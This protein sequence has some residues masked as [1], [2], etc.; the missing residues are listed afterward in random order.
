MDFITAV[1]G[2]LAIVLAAYLAVAIAKPEIF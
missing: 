1:A 2:L